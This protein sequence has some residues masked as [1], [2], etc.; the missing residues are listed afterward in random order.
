MS[1]HWTVAARLAGI[2]DVRLEARFLWQKDRFAHQIVL[3]TPEEERLCLQSLEG[4]DQEDFPPSPPLQDMS[5][6]QR[7]GS[8]VALGVG[9]AG[10]AMWSLSAEAHAEDGGLLFDWA[11]QT[12][13]A[14][15]WPKNCYFL[16]DGDPAA[17]ATSSQV[18]LHRWCGPEGPPI[19]VVLELRQTPATL[20]LGYKTTNQ[21]NRIATNSSV[22]VN[23][24]I[25]GSVLEVEG[26]P[27]KPDPNPA[28]S[29]T[30][31]WQYRIT[32]QF[33]SQTSLP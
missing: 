21:E 20:P 16:P 15:I 32:V 27:T 7:L 8:Q 31:R 22:A 5:V 33:A 17:K 25:G 30:L 11:C 1:K 19:E 4:N 28:K 2:P 6:E 12:R 24:S 18:V 29:V 9:M 23:D 14:D 13:G 3:I 10:S 26:V